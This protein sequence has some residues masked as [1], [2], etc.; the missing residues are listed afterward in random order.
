[1]YLLRQV[2]HMPWDFTS[3]W[4]VHIKGHDKVLGSTFP[5]PLCLVGT[6]SDFVLTP[7]ANFVYAGIILRQK[8]E[9]TLFSPGDL[10]PHEFSPEDKFTSASSDAR[11]F[12]VLRI[13][14]FCYF[15]R[16]FNSLLNRY[17][18]ASWLVG[19]GSL[20]APESKQIPTGAIEP[21]NHE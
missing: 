2:R 18:L 6:I 12:F 16:L 20:Q 15:R 5:Y 3:T 17:H 4:F 9:I 7:L 1:M 14:L 8:G 13:Q 10:V 19:N 11:S 21:G